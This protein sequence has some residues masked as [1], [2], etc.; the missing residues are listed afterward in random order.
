MRQPQLW[1]CQRIQRSASP[2]NPQT[3]NLYDYVGSDPTNH[4]DA[5]GRLQTCP[6]CDQNENLQEQEADKKG[7]ADAANAAN[8]AQ[9]QSKPAVTIK[10]E[11]GLG[12]EEKA[13]IEG[14]PLQEKGGGAV[15]GE[16]ELSSDG[17]TKVSAKMEIGG[18]IGVVKLPGVEVEQVTKNEHGQS[19]APTINIT[20]PGISPGSADVTGWR[21]EI[22]LGVAL[23]EGAGAGISI[24]IHPTELWNA[25]VKGSAGGCG[26]DFNTNQHGMGAFQ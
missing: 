8:E 14:T 20:K 17:T 2:H 24:T 7:K 3:L 5:D 11:G 13:A 15:K 10:V 1:W 12:L 21:N 18:K 19:E 23:C 4:A 9:K 26:C 25:M 6:G 16:L 22:T